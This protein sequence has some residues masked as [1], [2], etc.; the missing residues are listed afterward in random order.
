MRI[1]LIIVFVQLASVMS[2]PPRRH[3]HHDPE[4]AHCP[5]YP[6]CFE[7]MLSILSNTPIDTS[8]LIV[9]NDYKATALC[10]LNHH[11]VFDIDKSMN[12]DIMCKISK[13]N[14]IKNIG[15]PTIEQM[16]ASRHCFLLK[17]ASA[18]ETFD[19]V[20]RCVQKDVEYK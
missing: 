8:S 16:H 18:A 12:F 10:L 1:F 13:E 15:I 9:N 2:I 7:V 3:R 6:S 4:F 5:K 19:M 14:T 17:G 20:S 11:G